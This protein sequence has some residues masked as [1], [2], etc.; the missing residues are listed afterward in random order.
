MFQ[1]G[2][3]FMILVLL[4]GLVLMRESHQEPL[5]GLDENFADF[6]A[7]NARRTE[8]PAPVTLVGIDESSLEV[9]PWPWA[10][11]DFALFFQSAEIF[12]PAALATDEIL[13]WNTKGMKPENARKLLQY[14]KILREHVLRSS[15]VLLGARLGWP[16]DP[17]VLPVPQEAP[18]IRNVTGDLGSLPEFT[19][20]DDQADD[21]FR[22]SSSTGFVNLPGAARYTRTV[23]LLM[24]YHGQ[25]VPSFVLQAILMWEK[26]TP[27]DVAVEIGQ[28]IVLSERVQIPIDRLGR[29]RVDFG[30][31]RVRCGF[32]E[33]VLA[34]DQVEHGRTPIVPAERLTNKFVLLA[35]TDAAARTIEIAPTRFVSPGELFATAI[36]T[37]Q[38]RSFIKRIPDWFD[39]ALIAAAL[40]VAR[41]CRR[42]KKGSTLAVMAV[43]V[44]TYTMLAITY[45]AQ[46]LIWVPIVLPA[47]LA[48]FIVLFRLATPGI[49][50]EWD[51]PPKEYRD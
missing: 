20:I 8:D 29:M 7:I 34:S 42:W 21:D 30:A 39:F 11:L 13:S 43:F 36:A 9:R 25:V 27:D 37:I 50:S 28:Q 31:P 23:P 10:P 6:L 32:D 22:L 2:A 49:E 16:E 17:T 1:S 19:A 33:L 46:S 38:N 45:F 12:N 26:L 41:K 3:Q 24:R 44:V 47:G 4:A 5:R 35:R 40:L 15:R 48:L 51:L 14:Q 18:I